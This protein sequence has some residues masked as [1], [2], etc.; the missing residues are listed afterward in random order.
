MAS[1]TADTVTSR[2]ED[3]LGLERFWVKV[4]G[5]G[6]SPLDEVYRSP[7]LRVV[8]NGGAI[9]VLVFAILVVLPL[10]MAI[11][12]YVTHVSFEHLLILNF[13]QGLIK[14]LAPKESQSTKISL[15]YSRLNFPP[16]VSSKLGNKTV[17][18]EA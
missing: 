15:K 13:E 17:I 2:M 4:E 7:N 18:T 6:K 8:S 5:I 10:Q 9:S 3:S 11:P 12:E 14:T 1:A 16:P